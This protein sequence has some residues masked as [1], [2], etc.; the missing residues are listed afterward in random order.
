MSARGRGDPEEAPLEL[1]VSEPGVAVGIDLGTTNSAVA[2]VIDGVP[3]I[4]RCRTGQLLTPSVTAVARNGKRLVGHVAKR[5]AIT[6]PENTVSSAKRLIGRRWGSREVEDA[7]AMLPYRLEPGPE[8]D[9][10]VRM[11]DELFSVPELS[12]MV[13]QELRADA[14]AILGG[15]VTR[16]VITVP[17][18]FNDGQRQA[19]KQAGLIAGLDVLRI[20]NEPT[21]AALAYGFSKQMDKRAAV[22]DLGGGTFDIAVLDIGKDVFDV[23]AV[24][25]DSYLGGEDFDR[26]IVD[27]LAET[28]AARNGGLDIRQDRMALQ[29]LREAAEKAKCELSEAPST[30]IHLPFLAAGGE[31]GPAIH[32][33]LE[34]GREKLDALTGDLVERCMRVT[35]QTLRDAGLTPSQIDDVVLVG[36][37][38]RMASVQD[39]VRELFGREPSR[40]VHPEEVVALGAAIQ[41]HA[42]TAPSREATDALLLDV[43][44]HDLGILV[45]GGYA[46]VIIPRNTTI[47][48]RKTHV[49]TTSQD[50]QT[51]VRISVLQGSSHK[52]AEN[53][54]L[55]TF[56]LEG[57]RCAPRGEVEIEVTFDVSAEGILG[58]SAV[59]LTTGRQ[60]S[61]TVTASSG[62]TPEELEGIAE[63]HRKQDLP[64]GGATEA[65]P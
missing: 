42:L 39:A 40:A 29:R 65:G 28:F 6:N 57:I 59:D 47:P 11:G 13:L 62:L 21:S 45:V 49:F 50:G 24:G 55:A 61:I 9:V 1:R 36:G 63:A 32:L 20:L 14:E 8:N 60:H 25:G 27:W 34:M 10:R 41:A 58:V 38:T 2:A 43:T 48:T 16:A 46:R 44:P 54:L 22:F 52:A 30:S 53:E 33:E 35:Q 17:A 19:T 12:S 23:V 4:L 51:A 18:Y 31:G 3:R 7:R 5:Q 37:M 64:A 56:V 15:P 26:R